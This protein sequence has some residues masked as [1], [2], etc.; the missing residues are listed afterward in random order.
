MAWPQTWRTLAS[1]SRDVATNFDIMNDAKNS[2]PDLARLVGERLA[3]VQTLAES[4][5]ESQ[6]ALR[7]NNAEAIARG[8]AHQAELCRHWSRLEEQLRAEADRRLALP[9][10]PGLILLPADEQSARLKV[11]WEALRIRIRYLTRVHSS[12]LRHMQRSLSILQHVVDT[13]NTTYAPGSA[14]PA[15]NAHLIRGE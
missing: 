4:L 7:R 5:E 1:Y 13:C 11:E 2:L 8:A 12:L 10:T 14:L 9:A 3:V 6:D 15:K